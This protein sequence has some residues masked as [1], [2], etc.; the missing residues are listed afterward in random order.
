MKHI[1]FTFVLLLSVTTLLPAQS[2]PLKLEAR[3]G[4]S[5]TY[6]LNLDKGSPM[7][8]LSWA[9][10]SQNACFVE[11]RK[12]WFT[13][14]HLLLQTEIPKYSTMVIRLVPKDEKQN[15]S[16]YAY[17]GGQG[18]LPPGLNGCVSCEAD[19]KQERPSV[20][21]PRP[22]HTRSVEL[23]AVNRPY[24]VTIGVA[25]AEGLT[26]GGFYLEVTVSKNR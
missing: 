3:S 7:T 26:N 14:N 13:G 4:E 11:P 5:L 18:A 25:G 19:F 1:L 23:R 15:M 21:R 17:S 20:N 12:A 2:A 10:N 24:P 6:E 16:L 22:D 8:D 9:W